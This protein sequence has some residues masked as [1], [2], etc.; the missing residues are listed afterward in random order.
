MIQFNENI[1]DRQL[2]VFLGVFCII[3][4]STAV[5][6]PSVSPG[7]EKKKETVENNLQQFLTPWKNTTRTLLIEF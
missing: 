7:G 1:G 5:N 4:T 3:S 2:F 6:S